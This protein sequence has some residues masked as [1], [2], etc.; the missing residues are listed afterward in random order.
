MRRLPSLDTLRAFESAAR[1]LNFTKAANELHV[2]QS[3]LS[4]R[5]GALEDELG[6]PLFLRRGRQIDLTPRGTAIAQAMGRAMA[7][8]TR[9]FAGLEESEG[10]RTLVISVLPSF[11]TRWL[12]PR[13]MA[14]QSAHP[15]LEVQVNA[16]GR[17]IDLTASEA[18]L[19]VRFGTGRYP[20]HQ[21]DFIMDDYV[22][23]IAQP[24]LLASL[25]AGVAGT[26]DAAALA[27]LPLIFDSTVER[28]ASGTDW[29]SW[30]EHAGIADP[31]RP[32]GL[33]FSQADLMVQA[34]AQG[35]GIA[36]ARYSLVHDDLVARRLVPVLK[37]AMV[38]ARYDYYLVCLPEKA[39]RPA[40]A[41]FRAWLLA[42]ARNFMTL[43][44]KR[45][46]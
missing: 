43:R 42:E 46:A 12:M 28:D 13:M 36:L 45:S 39:E 23:P 14:F 19:A 18:D 37:N 9:A 40:V 35:Q 11:A 31:P 16:E 21:V 10:A 24:A 5:I 26:L 34:A 20:G 38:R 6:F 29:R 27:K 33:R 1:H 8:I 41:A 4:Q 2:T 44:E 25:R 30:F 22:L 3:A 32:T 17:L 7:E 15:T